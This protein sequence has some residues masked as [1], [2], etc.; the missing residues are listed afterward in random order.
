MTHLEVVDY[1][2]LNDNDTNRETH[3][4]EVEVVQKME[5]AIVHYKPVMVL[6]N[7]PKTALGQVCCLH[8]CASYM[9]EDAEY[10][11]IKGHSKVTQVPF[12]IQGWGSTLF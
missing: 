4:Y 8:R 6:A 12:L 2:L 7:S 11:Y 5:G 10:E 1:S 3:L 9:I